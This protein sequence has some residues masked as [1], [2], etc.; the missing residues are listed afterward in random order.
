MIVTVTPTSDA[1]SVD[2]LKD[3][4]FA[5]IGRRYKDWKIVD[6]SPSCTKSVLDYPSLH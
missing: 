2:D 6:V 5:Q 4:A 1:A 3:L